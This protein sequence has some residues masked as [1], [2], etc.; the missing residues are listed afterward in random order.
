MMQIPSVGGLAQ[1]E[2]GADAFREAGVLIVRNA[3]PASV[4][5]RICARFDPLFR[6]EFETGIYPDEWYWRE[7]LSLPTATRHMSNAWKADRTI[8]A[9]AMDEALARAAMRLGGWP[10]IRL[11]QDTLWWKVPGSKAAS[12]HQ[13]ASF[14]DFLAPPTMLTCWVALDDCSVG[15]GTLE[16]VPGSHR[17]EIT[18]RPVD[19]HHPTQDYKA[20]MLAAAAAAGQPEPEVGAIEVQAGSVV[21]HH[22]LT[23]HGSEANGSAERDRRSIGIHYLPLGARFADGTGGYIYG[24]YKRPGSDRLDDCFFPPI[25]P[26]D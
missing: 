8:A 17:W 21:F 15:S 12:F 5:E 4:V 16:Y 24:R 11:G 22:G 6:G 18:A 26:A 13:D 3:V 23:W 2:D 19:F 25:L 20:R 14:V 1:V 9:F 7:G 10:G